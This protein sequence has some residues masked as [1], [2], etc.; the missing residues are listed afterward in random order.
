MRYTVREEW[1]RSD[2]YIY[3][4]ELQSSSSPKKELGK[5]GADS[6]RA[7]TARIDETSDFYV[8]YL[9]GEIRFKV[10][11]SPSDHTKA[12]QGAAANP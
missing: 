2:V 7:K 1:E 8:F 5:F 12:E 3:Y 4:F 10:Q 6:Y 9:D 11:K